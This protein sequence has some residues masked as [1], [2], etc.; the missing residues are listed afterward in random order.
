MNVMKDIIKQSIIGALYMFMIAAMGA[1][2]VIGLYNMAGR[3]YGDGGQYGRAAAGIPPAYISHRYPRAQQSIGR[4]IRGERT[5]IS[6]SSYYNYNPSTKYILISFNYQSTKYIQIS[7]TSTNI[8][9]YTILYDP[10]Q[11]DPFFTIGKSLRKAV[12]TNRK[13][14]KEIWLSQSIYVYL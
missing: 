10:P 3:Q 1:V 12:K 8:Y 11:C 9:E 5:Q 6:Y 4:G 7:F 13:S 2:V 14:L